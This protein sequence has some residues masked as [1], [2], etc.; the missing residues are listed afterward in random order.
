MLKCQYMN[1]IKKKRFRKILIFSIL[2]LFIVSLILL[3]YFVSPE[4]IVDKIGVRNV[5]LLVFFVSFF[6]GFSAGG[7]VTFISLLVTFAAGGIN[8]FYLGIISGTSLAIGDM[9]MFHV[10]TRGRELVRGEWNKRINKVANI[11][12]KRKLLRK[13]VPVFAYIYIGLLPL[14]ND[15]LILFLAAI[16]YPEKKMNRII[17]LGDLIRRT[18]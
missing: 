9:I 10:G 4:Q 1:K 5:Y 17:I 7:S 16:K 14:P 15:I 3:L 6:G 18:Q 13:A 11:I 12:M 8:P 2:A